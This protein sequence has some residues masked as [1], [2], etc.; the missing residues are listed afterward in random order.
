M[1]PATATKAV[2]SSL[3]RPLNRYLRFTRQQPYHNQQQICLHLE[4]CLAY[5]FSARTF[6]QRFFSN[7]KPYPEEMVLF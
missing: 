1:D 2:F 6:L 4:K 3:A 5:Q 7:R